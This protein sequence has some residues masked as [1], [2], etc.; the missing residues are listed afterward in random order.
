MPNIIMLAGLSCIALAILGG[1]LKCTMVRAHHF[2]T[3]WR[4]LLL[5]VFG[6]VLVMIGLPDTIGHQPRG[7]ALASQKAKPDPVSGESERPALL[8]VRFERW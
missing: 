6:F 1:G 7:S 5:G 3:A 2:G 4:Q 8:A